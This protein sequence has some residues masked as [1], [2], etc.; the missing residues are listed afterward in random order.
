MG[1]TRNKK[2]LLARAAV[3]G[4]SPKP[5][6]K[7]TI[8]SLIEKTQELILEC[9]YDLAKQFIHR[10]LERDPGNVVAKEMLGVSQLETGE[11]Q[12]AKQVLALHPALFLQFNSN[13]LDIFYTVA[14]SCYNTT[15]LSAFVYGP[16]D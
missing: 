12:Q 15:P 1:R 3:S 16:A 6:N 5:S 4:S 14:P 7:P 13:F 11:L 9:D 2:Q 8:T 10:I